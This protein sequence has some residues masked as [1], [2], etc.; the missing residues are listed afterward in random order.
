MTSQAAVFAAAFEHAH[1]A[2]YAV[3]DGGAIAAW[4]PAAERL[5]GYT[6]AEAVGRPAA[7]LD[8]PVERDGLAAAALPPAAAGRASASS[9]SATRAAASCGPPSGSS[10]SSRSSRSVR[11][12]SGRPCWCA[13]WTP[14]GGSARRTI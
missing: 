2:F 4:N 11:R 13:P 8:L 6:A 5:Y 7:L 9:G 1:E 12:V 10:P 14:A 3:D